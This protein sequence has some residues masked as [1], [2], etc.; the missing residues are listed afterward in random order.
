MVVGLAATST[1]CALRL[2]LPQLKGYSL[3]RFV[4]PLSGQ[5]HDL[6]LL[7]LERPRIVLSVANTEIQ[8]L[9]VRE[10]ELLRR[11]VELSTPHYAQSP[12]QQA[13]HLVTELE[14]NAVS[15]EPICNPKDQHGP[16]G[17]VIVDINPIMTHVHDRPRRLAFSHV[18]ASCC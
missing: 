10:G 2:I 18:Q 13:R 3:Q 6:V 12:P 9:V 17:W 14:R 5:N 15:L 7:V 16:H 4:F 8:V 11:V 1:M